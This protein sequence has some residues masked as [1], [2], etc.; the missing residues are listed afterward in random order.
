MGGGFLNLSSFFIAFK[1][2][3]GLSTRCL[4]FISSNKDSLFARI[5]AFLRTI[6]Q[7]SFGSIFFFFEAKNYLKQKFT[8]WQRQRSWAG[9]VIFFTVVIF[10]AVVFLL[11]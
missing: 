8:F 4:W 9:A 5:S 2:Y 6:G 7:K 1:A 10:A 3:K 11:L